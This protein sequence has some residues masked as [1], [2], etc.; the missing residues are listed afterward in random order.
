MLN[1]D[2]GLGEDNTH[3]DDDEGRVPLAFYI[4]LHHPPSLHQGL[5]S[6][7]LVPAGIW[8][9]WQNPLE[10]GG[11]KFGRKACYFFSFQCLLFWQNLGILELRW[12]C[13]M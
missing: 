10:S 2:T 7:P 13:S 6:P 8:S 12:E 3:E 1:D 5:I 11:I 4:P 9:F